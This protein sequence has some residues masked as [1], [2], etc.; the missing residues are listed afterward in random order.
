[1]FAINEVHTRLMRSGLSEY[2]ADMLIMQL[3]IEEAEGFIETTKAI[4]KSL[5]GV[6]FEFLKKKMN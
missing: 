1:M 3:L 5:N 4:D 6:F 2:D